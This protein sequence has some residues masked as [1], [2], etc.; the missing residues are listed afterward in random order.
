MVFE[1]LE[2]YVVLDFISSGYKKEPSRIFDSYLNQ[3]KEKNIK[4]KNFYWLFLFW[5]N[6]E[7]GGEKIVYNLEANQSPR[8]TNYDP[9]CEI[10][11]GRWKFA[12]TSLEFGVQL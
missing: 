6:S 4:A 5:F 2:N 11:L 3:M 8:D 1:F 12:I 7:F 9:P 10:Y